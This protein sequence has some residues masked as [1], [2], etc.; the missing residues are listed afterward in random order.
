MDFCVYCERAHERRAT[1]TTEDPDVLFG[2]PVTDDAKAV[3][4]LIPIDI[5]RRIREEFFV[6]QPPLQED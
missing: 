3:L 2:V 5:E 4:D 6:E 1:V